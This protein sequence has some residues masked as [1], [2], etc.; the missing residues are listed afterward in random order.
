M[1]SSRRY[2]ERLAVRSAG[3][4]VLLSVEEVDWME[5][6]EN[7]VELHVGRESHLLQVTMSTL[8]KSLDPTSFL[9]VHRS[10]IVNLSRIRELRP[11]AHGEYI[12]ALRDGT[13]LQSGR[14]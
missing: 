13:R 7:Y 9:R 2:P 10:I 4:T 11:A 3:R 5:G 8:E 1:A 12:I 14:T 6:A